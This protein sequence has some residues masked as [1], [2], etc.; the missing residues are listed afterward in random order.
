MIGQAI[1]G[2]AILHDSNSQSPRDPCL[3]S[4]TEHPQAPT[5]A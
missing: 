4:Q 2:A 3:I 1:I 5:L